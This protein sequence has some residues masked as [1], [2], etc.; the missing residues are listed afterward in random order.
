MSYLNTKSDFITYNK[1]VESSET[2]PI[3]PTECP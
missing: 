2:D 1:K 3:D